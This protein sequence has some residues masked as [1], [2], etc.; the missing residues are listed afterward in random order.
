M[1]TPEAARSYLDR[2]LKDA[3]EEMA[4][5]SRRLGRAHSYL[6]QYIK[7]GK[8][9]YLRDDIREA[10]IRMVPSL[11][12]ERLKP[13]PI[14][15][16]PDVARSAKTRANGDHEPKI[17]A[18]RLGQFIDDPDTLEVVDIYRRI[19]DPAQRRRARNI[20]ELMTDQAPP[21]VA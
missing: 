13:D 3:G 1:A 5:L 9:I 17:N 18:P 21:A 6:Q 11:D 10:L 15:L 16:K 7:Y 8:P 20:L 4:S 19:T 14:E 12:G 2:A